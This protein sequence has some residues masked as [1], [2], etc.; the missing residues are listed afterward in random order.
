M[1]ASHPSPALPQSSGARASGLDQSPRTRRGSTNLWHGL[2]F[3]HG[4]ITHPETALSL[5]REDVSPHPRGPVD[6]SLLQRLLFLGGR[7]MH[8]GENFD[9]EEPLTPAI[10]AASAAGAAR[11]ANAQPC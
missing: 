3:L 6:M 4:H 11:C 5:A 7:P 1:K 2:L 8:A 10:R 9:V